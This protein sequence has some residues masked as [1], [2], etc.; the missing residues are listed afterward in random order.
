MQ[1]GVTNNTVPACDLTKIVFPS[2][3][4][5]SASTLIAGDVSHYGFADSVHPSP[6]TYRLLAQY[7]TDQML[8]AGWL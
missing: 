6:Y 5:C 3:L 8:K 4:V 7:V 1:Y 2:A